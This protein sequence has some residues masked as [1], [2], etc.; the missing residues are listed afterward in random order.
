M[1][2]KVVRIAKPY[3]PDFHVGFDNVDYPWLENDVEDEEDTF[4]V[5]FDKDNIITKWWHHSDFFMMKDIKEFTTE[6]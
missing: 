2:Y 5:E 4:I 1:K 3:Y 6:E